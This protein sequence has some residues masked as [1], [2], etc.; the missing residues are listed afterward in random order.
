VGRILQSE[1]ANFINKSK[2]IIADLTNERPNCYLE[3]GYAE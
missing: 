2:I 1:I 3:V